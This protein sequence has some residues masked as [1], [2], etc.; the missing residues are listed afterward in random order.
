VW[1]RKGDSA[2][3]PWPW[4]W[5]LLLPT[6]DARLALQ[7][8]QAQTILAAFT[9]MACASPCKC[10]CSDTERSA[11]FTAVARLSAVG[12]HDAAQEQAC[13]ESDMHPAYI[14]THRHTPALP[15]TI[16]LGA[17]KR[18]RYS[19]RLHGRLCL[20]AHARCRRVAAPLLSSLTPL[21]ARHH[22]QP[23]F[24]RRLR[25]GAD[26]LPGAS[27][28]GVK[29]SAW[30]CSGPDSSDTGAAVLALVIYESL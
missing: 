11:F 16:T 5:P 20:V 24:Q 22:R 15:Y 13:D 29:A 14:D 30:L 6:A 4:P 12:G 8:A 23:P 28:A 18:R 10:E 19:M 27:Q 3:W 17:K 7:P 2:G 9:A 21:R 1:K 26:D 25:A